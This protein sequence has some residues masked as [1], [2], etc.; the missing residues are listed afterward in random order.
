VWEALERRPS[1]SRGH[2]RL[3][4]GQGAR[5][6][7]AEVPRGSTGAQSRELPRVGPED[8]ACLR[9]ATGRDEN[10]LHGLHRLFTSPTAAEA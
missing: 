1:A 9:R 5:S 6:E 10:Q 8:R 7:N 2:V 3:P 4:E